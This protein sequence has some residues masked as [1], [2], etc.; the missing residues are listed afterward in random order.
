MQPTTCLRSA[1]RSP[2]P[3]RE[4]STTDQPERIGRNAR[5]VAMGL[6]VDALVAQVSPNFAIALGVYLNATRRRRFNSIAAKQD[7]LALQAGTLSQVT[8]SRLYASPGAAQRGRNG[9]ER[10]RSL[11]PLEVGLLCRTD[12]Q[13]ALSAARPT[14]AHWA[15]A[16]R[17]PFDLASWQR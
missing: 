15:I 14:S 9:G 3:P 12:Q 13:A 1:S 16:W 17:A 11:V 6:H 5:V 7:L 4:R 8:R 2:T 10:A